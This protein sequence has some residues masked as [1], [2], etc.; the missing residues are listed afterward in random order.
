M[1]PQT[2]WYIVSG[3]LALLFLVLSGPSLWAWLKA[4]FVKTPPVPVPATDLYAHVA[5]LKGALPSDLYNAVLIAV[6][7]YV[8]QP[9]K[10]GEWQRTTHSID[11]PT[12][13]C[14]VTVTEPAKEAT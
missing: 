9:V 10:L 13:K 7:G 14:E 8:P 1:N 4:R 12:G 6:C 11:L 5:A 2:A 3:V